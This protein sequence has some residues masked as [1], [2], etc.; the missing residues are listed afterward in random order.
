MRWNF[1]CA[2]QDSDGDRDQDSHKY[3]TVYRVRGK[4]GQSRICSEDDAHAK[5]EVVLGLITSQ[6]SQASREDTTCNAAASDRLSASVSVCKSHVD[7]KSFLRSAHVE[8]IGSAGPFERST[9][10]R[11]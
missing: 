1:L 3:S 8:A 11:L 7:G 9:S 4:P 6:V 10:F 2:E 5:G